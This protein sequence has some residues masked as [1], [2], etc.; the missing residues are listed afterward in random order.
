M[1][2][3]MAMIAVATSRFGLLPGEDFV[4]ITFSLLIQGLPEPCGSWEEIIEWIAFVEKSE[5][6]SLFRHR[7]RKRI[8]KLN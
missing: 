4:F 5:P 3:A 1:V 2:S 6:Q 7:V 8:R